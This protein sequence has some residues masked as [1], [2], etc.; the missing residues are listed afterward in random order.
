MKYNLIDNS[1]NKDILEEL[2]SS[3]NGALLINSK[4]TFVAVTIIE[5][6]KKL[7][8]FDT[9]KLY[10]DSIILNPNSKADVII[11]VTSKDDLSDYSHQELES[12]FHIAE[13]EVS[14][15]N[16]ML[17]NIKMS[18]ASDRINFNNKNKNKR[19]K[20]KNLKLEIQ[21]YLKTNNVLLMQELNK[22]VIDIILSE[23]D[24][25]GVYNNYDDF[26]EE[27]ENNILKNNIIILD[28]NI[29][30]HN[31]VLIDLIYNILSNNK[32]IVCDCSWL[33]Y[34]LYMSV[35]KIGINLVSTIIYTD[36]I[37]KP[38]GNIPLYLKEE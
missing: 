26:M 28:F 21:Q 14:E 20:V 25:V 22:D 9:F 1:K 6:L 15:D 35:N 30:Y 13:L 17:F 27:K 31:S 34:F 36:K 18:L 37:L 8:E 32:I 2:I 16:K 19:T 33:N 10:K 5:E 12:D 24:K 38:K 11:I 23:S 3:S 29:D 4:N 7:T